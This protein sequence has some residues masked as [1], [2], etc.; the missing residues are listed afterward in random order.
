MS[1]RASAFAKAKELHK[2]ERE[3]KATKGQGGGS[4]FEEVSF[5]A[6]ENNRETVVR[7]LGLPYPFREKGSDVKLINM[8]MI[9]GDDDKK[10]RFIWPTKEEN[11]NWIL[12]K[13][14]DRVM[15]YKWN[16]AESKKEFT[17]AE[18]HPAIFN[19]VFKNDKPEQT[20]ESGWTPKPVCLWN[21][22]DRS[23]MAW[24]K[25]NNK[26]KVLSKKLSMY[27]PNKDKVWYEV[28]VPNYLY[29]IIWNSVVEYSGD[30]LDYD[31]VLSKVSET[32][33]YKAFHG[34]DEIKKL[35]I[36]AKGLVFD[37]PLTDEEKAFERFDFDKLY[38][39]TSYGKIKKKLGVFIQRVDAAFGTTYT[40]E[41]NELA[42][43]EEAAKP[44]PDPKTEEP[45][46][47]VENKPSAPSVPEEKAVEPAKRTRA[48]KTVEP[49]TSGINW[50]KM[51]ETFEGIL[52]MSDEEK[53][54][55]TS[56]NEDGTWTY[57]LSDSDELFE[58]SNCQFESPGTFDNC[59]N[60]GH[61]F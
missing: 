12:R 23:D 29:E 28:G 10:S 25:E 46:K 36:E 47:E 34:V 35:S 9:L 54:S 37:G 50:D 6:L 53:S 45:K 31:V 21:V 22:I 56:I 19:R 5:V 39:V 60:C 13:V 1:D 32:P 55:V 59:P 14:F 17:H 44:K 15:D 24:H 40:N 11:P 57:N 49:E 42:A 33:W 2:K 20:Y 7:L 30:W 3:E 43:E 4:N 61:S 38:K 48:A 41:L 16:S 8:S 52:K 27:G 18:A 51:S 26:T 58:C